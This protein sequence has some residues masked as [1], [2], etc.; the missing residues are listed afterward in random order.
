MF[1]ADILETFLSKYQ[2]QTPSRLLKK[3]KNH[4]VDIR[5][6]LYFVSRVHIVYGAV[7]I[8]STKT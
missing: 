1:T 2:Q 4:N 7:S 8:T 5:I 6:N 3:K